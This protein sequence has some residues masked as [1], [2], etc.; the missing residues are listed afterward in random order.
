MGRNSRTE[1]FLRHLQFFFL[2]TD[3]KNLD[4]NVKRISTPKFNFQLVTRVD[5]MEIVAEQRAQQCC[6]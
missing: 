2:V 5:K 1:L 4:N 3:S 6:S